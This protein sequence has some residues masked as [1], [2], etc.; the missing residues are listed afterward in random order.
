MSMS[1]QY[2]EI[3][4]YEFQKDI[5]EGNFGK[6][7]LGIFK[8]TGE[9]FAIKILNKSK[10]KIKMKNSI[11]KENEIIR[12]FNHI[13][14]VYVFQILED[15]QNFYIIMEYCKHGELFDY[16]VK[17]ERLT[18]EESSIFFYQL[19]NGIEYI[20]SKGISHRDLKPENLLLAEK[21]ILKII[22]F[23]LSHEFEG[24]ELLKTKCGSPSYAAPEIICC[25]YYDGFKVDV[26]CC[27]IILYAMLCGYLP[28][29]G[30]D[31]NILFQN[32]LNC[33]PD[34]PPF[35]SELSKDIILKILNPVP[36]NRI[37]ISEIKKHKFYLKGKKL[38]DIDYEN[39]ENNIIKKRNIFSKSKIKNISINNKSDTN[40]KNYNE[41]NSDKYFLTI[42]NNDKS[43][44]KKKIKLID[45]DSNN[46]NNKNEKSKNKMNQINH[47]NLKNN[48]SAKV[49]KNKNKNINY[50]YG[51]RIDTI[52]NKIQEI[53]KTD[54]NIYKNSAR[55][56]SSHK[57]INNNYSTNINKNKNIS[58]Q[59]NYNSNNNINKK[60][61]SPKFIDLI[62]DNKH[63]PNPNP[64]LNKNTL[65][66]KVLDSAKNKYFNLYNDKYGFI[67]TNNLDINDGQ[68]KKTIKDNN[69]FFNNIKNKIPKNNIEIKNYYKN[70]QVISLSNDNINDIEKYQKTCNN[71]N[72]QRINL[73]KE[74]IKNE[75]NKGKHQFKI[76][77][78]SSKYETNINKNA[79]N[80]NLKSPKN[81]KTSNSNNNSKK[82]NKTKPLNIYAPNSTLYY[83]NININIKELNINP[84]TSKNS[85]TNIISSLATNQDLKSPLQYKKNNN[86]F[87]CTENKNIIKNKAFSAKRLFSYSINTNNIHNLKSNINNY[88]NEN[89]YTISNNSC[90]RHFFINTINYN[91][92]NKN[93]KMNKYK[94]NFYGLSK[95]L[96]F[97]YSEKNLK[98]F[99]NER[100][101]STEPK[102]IIK[103]QFS[104]NKAITNKNKNNIH[105]S[106]E[107]NNK[108]LFN[109][110]KRSK[111]E[112]II[113]CKTINMDG[114]RNRFK[115]NSNNQSS[116]RF[117]YKKGVYNNLKKK[118]F[119]NFDEMIL[120]MFMEEKNN[121]KNHKIK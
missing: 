88:N 82:Q 6:V 51:K 41:L 75:K 85:K 111:T 73:F 92:K 5:G 72:N 77:R 62:T 8:P 110:K 21:K 37:S 114:G 31:N 84:K 35:L 116:K 27:G 45:T 94:N 54:M 112:K 44:N 49:F 104:F 117:I 105:I 30:E 74:S 100:I 24:D 57:N 34:F 83:N 93:K 17:N 39:I 12:K 118:K 20:H 91:E 64:K 71:R 15:S 115:D 10:I 56:F 40:L 59:E 95:N 36:E 80:Q 50:K 33:N 43:K 3:K 89:L 79:N 119:N 16:I 108:Y 96:R 11:F 18:E 42:N 65:L 86:N 90:N 66:I 78:A 97:V 55:P 25:P 76:K 70:D 101:L 99:K 69:S 109:N 19:I 47:N 107:I 26:W 9:E 60:E 63:N 106:N 87:C 48:S 68:N 29:E 13:N 4:N 102:E 7:K 28:F 23:G 38:C 46:I 2:L 22:D 1:K 32:I 58:G 103:K 52:T 121:I 67:N 61:L 81:I 120:L 53:L 113:N 14:V 98:L